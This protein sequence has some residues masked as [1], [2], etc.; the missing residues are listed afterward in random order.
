MTEQNIEQTI[1]DMLVGNGHEFYGWLLMRIERIKDSNQ[2]TLYITAHDGKV[3]MHYNPD[4]FFSKTRLE[5]VALVEHE[6]LH[7]SLGHFTRFQAT[8]TKE[9]A[10]SNVACDCAINQLIDNLPSDKDSRPVDWE[11]LNKFLRQ[12]GMPQ[13]MEKMESS[14]Y[15]LNLLNKYVKEQKQ[16]GYGCG[17][18]KQKRDIDS[19]TEAEINKMVEDAADAAGSAPAEVEK[20]IRES[21]KTSKLNWKQM[22]ALKCNRA[23]KMGSRVSWKRLRRRSE[24]ELKGKVPDYKPKVVVA[25]DTSGSIF[26]DPVALEQFETQ[27][28]KIQEVYKAEFMVVECDADIQSTYKL[29]SHTKL[30]GKYKGGGGTDFRP[31]FDLCNK[32]LRPGV[33]VFLTDGYG[34]FPAKKPKYLTIWVTIANNKSDFPFGEVIAI[35]P[36][37]K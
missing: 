17:S 21:K 18:F 9:Q 34:T 22:L 20:Q 25:V 23:V 28:K 11:G 13:D 12:E 24:I 27:I 30:S 19:A 4:F 7:L 31:V 35:E 1:Q 10:K 29:R 36:E 37:K 16:T 14:E 15:Y 33:L 3:E 5:R 32:K 8:S 26:G 2:P 6:L